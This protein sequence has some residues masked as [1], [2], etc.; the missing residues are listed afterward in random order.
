MTHSSVALSGDGHDVS[1]LR[2]A[3]FEPV[4]ELAHGVSGA[5]YAARRGVSSGPPENFAVKL[6]RVDD[7]HSTGSGELLAAQAQM[8]LDHPNILR[9]YEI[10]QL[11]DEA[12][13]VMPLVAGSLADRE[14][15]D[16]VFLLEVA[17]QLSGA[18]NAIHERDLVHG[19]VKPHNVLVDDA[20]RNALLTDFGMVTRSGRPVRGFTPLFAAPELLG[21]AN[22]VVTPAIDI[23]SLA[24][25]IF[26]AAGLRPNADARQD[27]TWVAEVFASPKSQTFDPFTDLLLQALSADPERRPTA[28]SLQDA[29]LP[30][31][32][33]AQAGRPLLTLPPADRTES[34]SSTSRE[35]GPFLTSVMAPAAEVAS[36]VRKDEVVRGRRYVGNS[37]LLAITSLGVSILTNVASSLFDLEAV[38]PSLLTVLL[39]AIVVVLAFIVSS[40]GR[41]RL[42]RR[43]AGS[44][45]VQ[46]LD[47]AARLRKA[48]ID[49]IRSPVKR[50]RSI[51]AL[52]SVYVTVAEPRSLS[53]EGDDSI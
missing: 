24:V 53:I 4:S 9:V 19:D 39:L 27:G 50:E 46:A 33:Q 11:N 48:Y 5:V 23:Y 16:S 29:L 37:A 21:R 2:S 1:V 35:G 18:L 28:N 34:R 41:I 25:S 36:V 10:K 47:V 43:R 17:I 13:V 22:A 3:G 42:Q 20:T 7:G 40:Y 38:I 15:W 26:W 12:L 14:S 52:R 6:I 31:R 32:K 8:E 30:L 45:R 49:E 51:L 44:M